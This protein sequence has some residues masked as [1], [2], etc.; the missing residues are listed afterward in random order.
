MQGSW[1][2]VWRRWDEPAE[3]RGN[4]ASM[5][6]LIVNDPPYGTERAY[7]AL[8]LACALLEREGESV[9][10]FLS[11]TEHRTRSEDRR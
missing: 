6:L 11:A 3:P 8:R 9:Q 7:N 2:F 1:C 4:V 10:I 5:S